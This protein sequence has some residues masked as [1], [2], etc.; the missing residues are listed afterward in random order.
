MAV[1]VAVFVTRFVA[2]F[3]G[4]FVMGFRMMV[5]R[6]VGDMATTLAASRLPL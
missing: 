1:F 5:F 6:V 2:V 3:V 4:V